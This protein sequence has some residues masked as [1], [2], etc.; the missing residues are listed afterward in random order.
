MVHKTYTFQSIEF[1][2]GMSSYAAYQKYEDWLVSKFKRSDD[3]YEDGTLHCKNSIDFRNKPHMAYDFIDLDGNKNY[4]TMCGENIRDL[5][6][7]LLK[8][9]ELSNQQIVENVD[10]IKW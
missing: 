7:S 10:T 8:F 1:Q 3:V 4:I 9:I 5:R 6:D 2:V